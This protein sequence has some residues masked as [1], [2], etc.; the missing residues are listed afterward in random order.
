MD[1][2]KVGIAAAKAMERI[3]KLVSTQELTDE[4]EL[5]EVLVVVAFHKPSPEEDYEDRVE[6]MIFVD[7][8]TQVPYVQD[9][10]LAYARMVAGSGGVD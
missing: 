7:G 1:T 6:T 4:D 9:G 5:A 8:T 10:L 3:D 2:S